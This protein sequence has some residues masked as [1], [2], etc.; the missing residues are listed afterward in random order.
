MTGPHPWQAAASLAARAHGPQMRRDGATPYASHPV[1]VAL[2]VALVF[3]VTDETVVT[4]A[5]LH[6]VIED[7][8]L[9]Y[10]DLLKAFG[11]PV[12][13][14]VAALSKDP[15]LVEPRREARYDEQLGAAAWQA[16]LIKLADVY[17]NFHDSDAAGRAR[18]RD[19]VERALALARG[20]PECSRAVEIVE[21]MLAAA[22]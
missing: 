5:L 10:D 1:R 8:T 15:R 16:K 21:N 9:D 13:D 4:A 11:Q 20:V 2:T 19:K 18:I 22:P 14:L 6:D 17:D 3:G 12:A 7:T